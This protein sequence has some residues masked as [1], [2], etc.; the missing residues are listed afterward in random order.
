MKY[1]MLACATAFICISLFVLSSES[2]R[3]LVW[4]ALFGYSI[5]NNVTFN[6][7]DCDMVYVY[8][9]SHGLISNNTVFKNSFYCSKINN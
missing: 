9:M 4:R 7:S 6:L 1:F 2:R 8:D 5:L 3:E